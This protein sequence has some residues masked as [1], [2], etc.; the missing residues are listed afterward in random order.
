VDEELKKAAYLGLNLV[1]L[2]PDSPQEYA[3]MQEVTTT[4]VAFPSAGRD[5]LTSILRQGAQ[6]ML[7]MAIE[8]EVAEWIDSHRHLADERGHR[9]VVRNGY[10]PE[11]EIITGLGSIQVRQP[12][13]HDRR[14]GEE[15]EV[16]SSKILPPYLRKTKSLEDLLPW[17]YLK[18]IS[19]G[20]FNEALQALVGPECPGLSASTITR[21]LA[22]WQDDYKDWSKR[23]LKDKHY[24][25]LWVDGVHFNIRLEED[26]Q[27]ILVLMGATA[28]GHK[29][30][31]ALHDGY[32]ESEQSWREL[33]L[34]VKS[35][36]LS[37]DPKLATGDGALGFWK[38]LPQ[39]FPTTRT[40]RCWV[41]KTANVLDRLPKR[42]QPHAK[43]MIHEIWMADTRE[44]AQ[45]AFDAFLATYGPKYPQACECLAKDRDELLAFYD[46]PAEHWIH[47][48]TT[49]PIESVFATVRLRHK[50]TKGN[51]S[52]L[53]CLA[54]VHQ[55]ML[56]ASKRWKLL[57]GAKLIPD[58][59][60]GVQFIDGV[61]SQEVAA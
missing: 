34:D 55:L 52:R 22:Q 33:L 15:R 50:R 19:T 27:C 47:L 30:L 45:A 8:A 3:T 37:I 54:M 6:Q 48:R 42:L 23:P 14:T 17:L 57:N 58:V 26:R 40:Q 43:G 59:I 51:G 21:L 9:Q 4:S 20:D 60:Q 61:K 44:A 38:A 35:R 46:F 12:R 13:V 11:R 41:H 53:A 49:N 18:G 1:V 5:A 2:R 56:S 25:Y 31:I 16:F 28:D 24:V 32:R 29:E 7:T 10:L 36:G 39:V